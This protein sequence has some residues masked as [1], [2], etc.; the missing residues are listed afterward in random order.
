MVWHRKGLGRYLPATSA[1]PPHLYFVNSACMLGCWTLKTQSCA[2]TWIRSTQRR[3]KKAVDSGQKPVH[4]ALQHTDTQE[5]QMPRGYGEVCI[6]VTYYV[7]HTDTSALHTPC[8]I[9]VW[10]TGVYVGSPNHVK[11]RLSRAKG[12]LFLEYHISIIIHCIY[13]LH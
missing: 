10:H 2:G 3:T 12:S 6:T 4:L 13:P 11:V 7:V 5:I 9:Q 1:Y 8:S